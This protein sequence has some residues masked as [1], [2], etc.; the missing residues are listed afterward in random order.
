[1]NII[2]EQVVEEVTA[3]P[4]GREGF[5]MFS[6][7]ASDRIGGIFVSGGAF[8]RERAQVARPVARLEGTP[9]QAIHR[10]IRILE[11]VLLSLFSEHLASRLWNKT[12]L[13]NEY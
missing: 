6:K 2:R 9:L 1:M 8:Q 12:A 4:S 13:Q 7:D 11:F 10:T 3:T 5:S